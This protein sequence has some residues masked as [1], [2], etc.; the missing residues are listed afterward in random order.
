MVRALCGVCVVCVVCVCVCRV[1][2]TH[3]LPASA[4]LSR[5]CHKARNWVVSCATVPSVTSPS[6][7]ALSKNPFNFC[8]RD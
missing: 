4:K 2:Q 1:V 6:P 8:T 7:I 3:L 5:I